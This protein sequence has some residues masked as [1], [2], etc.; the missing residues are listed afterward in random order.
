MSKKKG[1][2]ASRQEEEHGRVGAH[3]TMK[4]QHSA[5]PPRT[6][7]APK[8]VPSADG[9]RS[10]ALRVVSLQVRGARALRGGL[11]LR[12]TAREESKTGS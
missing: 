3:C 11:R 4:R 8:R 7:S 6:E 1:T 10:A 2:R 12:V 5:T 9:E